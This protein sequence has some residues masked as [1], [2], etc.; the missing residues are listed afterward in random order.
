MYPLA[1]IEGGLTFGAVVADLILTLGIMTA[2]LNEETWQVCLVRACQVLVSGGFLGD[3]AILKEC[4]ADV[5]RAV[6]GI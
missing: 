6:F 4:S 2:Q 5:R 3:E 1:C